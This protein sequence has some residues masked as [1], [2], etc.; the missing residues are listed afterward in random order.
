MAW[1]K[2]LV[3]H[4]MFPV[5]KAAE[6]EFSQIKNTWSFNGSSSIPQFPVTGVVPITGGREGT[7][8][9]RWHPDPSTFLTCPPTILF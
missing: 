1:C 9:P 2:G 7:S 4:L 8:G 5:H 3:V 6:G